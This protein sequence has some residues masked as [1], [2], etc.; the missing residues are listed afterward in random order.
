MNEFHIKLVIWQDRSAAQSGC[1][2]E[3]HYD[4]LILHRVMLLSTFDNFEG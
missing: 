1:L 4:I 3:T 2:M